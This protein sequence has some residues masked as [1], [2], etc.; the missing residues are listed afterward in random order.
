MFIT[1]KHTSNAVITVINLIEHASK[2]GKDEETISRLAILL[3]ILEPLLLNDQNLE[4]ALE[5]KT[6]EILISM[7][8]LPDYVGEMSKNNQLENIKLPIY[9]KYAVRC[10]TS[11]IRHPSGVDQ[12]VASE[13]GINS[14]IQ[15]IQLVRDE[16]II[17]NCSKI[18][19]IIYREEKVS[20]RSRLLTIRCYS[21]TISSSKNTAVSATC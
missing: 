16:E 19:R 3:S 21:T 13:T 6:M 18:I 7:L 14:I 4:K 10:I 17:A 1:T 5:L 15:F 11:C 12:L 20:S 8:E 9:I 2:L